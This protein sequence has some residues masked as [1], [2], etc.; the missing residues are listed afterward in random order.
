MQTIGSPSFQILLANPQGGKS[1]GLSCRK[2]PTSASPH[3]SPL[4]G[5]GAEGEAAALTKRRRDV[6]SSI[7]KD[8]EPDDSA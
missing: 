8:A 1:P 4:R 5:E 2:G 3:P 6:A 7:R